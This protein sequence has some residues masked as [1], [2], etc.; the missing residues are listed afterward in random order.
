[1]EIIN[2]KKPDTKYLG[3]VI[4]THNRLDLTRITIESYI[5]TIVVPHEL[6]IIDNNSDDETKEY[7]KSLNANII[8]LDEFKT[9]FVIL[10]INKSAA[11][12]FIPLNPDCI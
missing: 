9:V 6:L 3:S 8:F 4:V 10:P 2:I 7:L 12:P 11:E 1:V 5:N